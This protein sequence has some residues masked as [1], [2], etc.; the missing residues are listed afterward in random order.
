MPLPSAIERLATDGPYPPDEDDLM[1]FGRLVGSWD[2]DW[3]RLGDGGEE[4]ERRRVEWHFA[5]VL[6][7]RAVQDVIFV[8]GEPPHAD[9]TTLRCWDHEARVWRSTFMSPHDGEY[10]ALTGRRD[11]DRI[12]QDVTGRSERWVFPDITDEAFWGEARTRTAGGAWTPTHRMH[13]RRRAA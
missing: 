3:L 13:A 4:V 8:A 5:W 10:F 6:G 11:G 7:G 9:G 1:L 2:V 12:D